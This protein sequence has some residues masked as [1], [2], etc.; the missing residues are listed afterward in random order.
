[1]EFSPIC[2]IPTE[3]IH[4]RENHPIRLD[5]LEEFQGQVLGATGRCISAPRRADDQ[6]EQVLGQSL[7]IPQ[8]RLH[9]RRVHR[10][11]LVGGQEG[12]SN[13]KSHNPF[14]LSKIKY[15]LI[16]FSF[17]TK[18]AQQRQVPSGNNSGHRVHTQG[19][20]VLGE[21]P[22]DHVLQVLLVG[23]FRER[24]EHLQEGH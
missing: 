12:G 1:M 10:E 16:N 18:V 22:R 21:F 24:G 19:R 11:R 17:V 2:E 20:R 4:P 7:R 15:S 13:G 14:S 5:G 8:H 9:K 23:S 3:S 6:H